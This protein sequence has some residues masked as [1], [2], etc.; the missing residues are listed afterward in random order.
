MKRNTQSSHYIKKVDFQNR[1]ES[2]RNGIN[3]YVKRQTDGLIK[4]LMKPGTVNADTIIILLN[5]FTLKV[6]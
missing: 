1:S 6:S 4:D 5:V 2:L 3:K